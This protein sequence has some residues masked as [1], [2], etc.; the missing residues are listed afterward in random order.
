MQPGSD[1]FDDEGPEIQLDTA[2]LDDVL[3]QLDSEPKDSLGDVFGEQK[4]FKPEA[5]T[6][7]DKQDL[8]RKNQVRFDEIP[9]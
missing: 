4:A 3:G 1:I 7:G 8:P 2:G 6:F 5:V 9:V